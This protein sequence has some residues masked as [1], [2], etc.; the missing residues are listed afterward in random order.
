MLARRRLGFALATVGGILLATSGAG[1][2]SGWAARAEARARWA[3]EDA[4]SELAAFSG[5]LDGVPG[6]ARLAL[7]APV[8]RLIIPA[9]EL[10][11]IVLE[12]VTERQLR[13]GPSHLPGSAVPGL[14]GNAIVSAHRD[15]HFH[16]LDRLTIGDTIIT[17]TRHN[18]TVW[19]LDKRRVIDRHAPAL[20]DSREPRLTLTTCWPVRWFGPAPDRL[21]LTAIP[22]R[23]ESLIGA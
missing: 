9:L 18:R 2:A 6:G 16:G 19:A 10:D 20:F 22:V 4:R 11:E 15:R 17:E 8:A 13:A 12:G 7:D 21:I 14:A 5:S 1:Y 23:T 3:A